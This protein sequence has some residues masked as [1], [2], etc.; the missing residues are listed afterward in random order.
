MRLPFRSLFA[1]ALAAALVVGLPSAA[2]ERPEIPGVEASDAAPDDTP[3]AEDSTGELIEEIRVVGNRRVEV[4]AIRRALRNQKGQPFRPELTREDIR[5]LWALNLF[6]DVRLL[7]Q[8]LPKG[9]LAYVVTVEERPAIREVK[10][11]G[12]EELSTED[13]KETLD[14]KPG[15]ILDLEAVRKNV[16]AVQD[17]YIEKGFFLAEVEYRLDPVPESADVDVVIVIRE[18]AKVLVKEIRFLGVENVAVADLKAVMAT[19]EGNLLSFIS[20]EGTYREE[21]FQRDLQVIQAV[22]YDNGYV[23]V[24]VDKPSISLSADKRFIFITLRITEGEQYDIG[25]LGFSGDLLFPEAELAAKMTAKDGET[26]NRSKLGTDIQTL[27]DL[28]YDKGYAYANISP[29]TQIHPDDKKLDLT[30]DIQKGNQVYVERIE[31]TGNTKTRDKVIRRELRIAEGELFSGTALRRSKER[32]TALGFFETVEV[33]HK[34]GSSDTRVVVSVEV[35]EKP[36]GTFQLGFGFSNVESFI[37]TGQISQ[38]NFLGWGWTVSASVQWSGL[39]NLAQLSFFDPY[40]LDTNFIFSIDAYIIETAYDQFI[41]ASQGGTLNLGYHLFEDVMANVGYTYERVRVEASGGAGSVLLADRFRSGTTSALRTSATWDR[42]DN[43]L[44]PTAG[45]MHFASV[46]AAP[47]FLGGSFQFMRY[48][49]YSR[50]YFPLPLGM[51]FKT[52]A[53]VGYIQPLSSDSPLPVSELYYLGGIQTLR[54]FRLRTVSPTVLVATDSRPDASTAPFDVGGN[55]QVI[56]NLELEFPLIAGAGVRGVVFYDAGNAYAPNERFFQ[57]R[58]DPNVILGMFHSVGFGFRWFS[59]IGPL[60]FEWGI[61]LT[62]R[63]R[64]E[65][66]NFEFN[67][68]NSF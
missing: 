16:K 53:T 63:P 34:P 64:D 52:N 14:L 32:V 3:L 68:G 45:F 2:Q 60:R 1:V 57:D 43:R 49:A 35:A 36:T 20:G 46:E 12:N 21:L 25:K 47:A 26:F 6:S 42:R 7:V 17:K 31:I 67:I 19:K 27:T 30:F 39:R 5:A 58:Q 50:L 15:T 51:V 13:F 38:N 61:P 10:L 55:K 23:N 4:E 37:L 9:G 66:I 48:T 29:L 33:T 56:F 41:R 54:G 65:P 8:R 24:A 62:K 18:R 28:Y 40:F 22:Y 44:F 59:P 11:Q